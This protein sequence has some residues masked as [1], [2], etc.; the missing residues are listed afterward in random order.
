V[1]CQLPWGKSQGHVVVSEMG[2]AV[3]HRSRSALL[4]LTVCSKLFDGVQAC[5]SLRNGEI[6]TGAP[7]AS[8]RL[9]REAT[10]GIGEALLELQESAAWDDRLPYEASPSSRSNTAELL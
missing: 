9:Q 3:G 1:C 8:P 2:L 6:R 10:M 4:A 5:S 7:L